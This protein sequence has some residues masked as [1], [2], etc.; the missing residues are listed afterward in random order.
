MQWKSE[1]TT[2]IWGFFFKQQLGKHGAQ[3]SKQEKTQERGSAREMINGGKYKH[4]EAFTMMAH[5]L[6]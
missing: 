5:Y 6:L 4:S 3:R 1:L 2:E